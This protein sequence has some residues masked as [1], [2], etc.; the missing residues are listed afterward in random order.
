MT[1][2]DDTTTAQ[3]PVSRGADTELASLAVNAANALR[4]E[5]RHYEIACEENARLRAAVERVRGLADAIDAEMRIEPDTQRAAMQMEAAVQ[6]RAAL[7][8]YEL[9][10]LAAET[11]VSYRIESRPVG[12][13]AWRPS[14]LPAIW[15]DQD[16]AEALLATLRT[17]RPDREH[18][19]ITRT[20]VTTETCSEPAAGT[21]DATEGQR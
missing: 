12:S 16:K 21:Q 13:D 4:D 1:D 5:K 9:R 10:R 2:E 8:G 14:R 19:L 11:S 20:I 18:R 7:N 3:T 17:S 6:I 15:N